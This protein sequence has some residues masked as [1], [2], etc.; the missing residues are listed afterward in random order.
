MSTTPPGGAPPTAEAPASGQGHSAA[1]TTP[2]PTLRYIAV[3]G[4]IG[5]GKTSLALRLARRFGGKT[6]LEEVDENPFL[7]SFYGDRSRWAFHTQ[8]SYLASRFRQQK[9][10]LSLDLFHGLIVSD[11]AFDKDRIFAH[12]N[13]EG[14]ELQLYESLY[15]LMATT[16]PMPDVVVYLQARLDRLL[17][18]IAIRGRSY[19][20]GMD[21]SYLGSLAE[22]YDFYFERY[23]G[24]VLKLDV[25]EVDFVGNE[26]DFESVIARILTVPSP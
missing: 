7:A 10:L 19:E 11:Y 20:T 8:L 26:Q 3:E 25:T 12:L 16:I 18:N 9:S 2:P 17:E 14:D 5:V 23:P 6:L 24:R 15:T 13:L 21:P 1:E 4:V 22:A